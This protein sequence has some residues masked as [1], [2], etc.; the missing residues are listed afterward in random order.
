MTTL[1]VLLSQK[2]GVFLQE[3][4]Y[5]LQKLDTSSELEVEL[6]RLKSLLPFESYSLN[7]I[8]VNSDLKLV[9][10]EQVC[11]YPEEWKERYLKRKYWRQADVVYLERFRK[12]TYSIYR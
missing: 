7:L 10:Y 3:L 12:N 2:D 6:T 5:N 4:V 9:D 11:S 8:E 1:D